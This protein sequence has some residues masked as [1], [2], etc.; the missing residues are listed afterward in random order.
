MDEA[1]VDG[2]TGILTMDKNGSVHREQLWAR[3]E[4][5]APRLLA[6]QPEPGREA[7][8]AVSPESLLEREIE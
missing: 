3:F 1:F 5:G 2:Q 6:S 8:D 7:E 4:N